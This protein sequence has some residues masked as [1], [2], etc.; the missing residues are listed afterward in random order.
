MKRVWKAHNPD[1]DKR[2]ESDWQ[3]HWERDLEE[4]VE[5]ND[6]ED[7]GPSAWSMSPQITESSLRS[8]SPGTTASAKS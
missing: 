1:W 4:A 7:S 2:A 5:Q 6:E 8:I 3:G